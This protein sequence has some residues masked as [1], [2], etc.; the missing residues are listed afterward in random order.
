MAIEAITEIHGRTV[1]EYNPY[2]NW[3]EMKRESPERQEAKNKA[4]Q[5][6]KENT[7]TI[8]KRGHLTVEQ[9][10]KIARA[11]GLVSWIASHDVRFTDSNKKI[12]VKL[13]WD[14]INAPPQK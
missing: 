8:I 12:P 10:E 6:K 7:K 2:R 1:Q 3:Y 5:W 13:I 11:E 4:K 9:I 14:G